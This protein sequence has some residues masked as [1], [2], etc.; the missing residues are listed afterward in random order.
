MTLPALASLAELDARTPGGISAAD[1]VRALAALDD[2]SAMVRSV[3]GKTWT[4]DGVL[5]DDVPHVVVMVTCAVARRVM[6]NP[7]GVEQES[8]DD[9]S[10]S[11]TN[12]SSDIY[13]TAA[14]RAAVRAAAGKSG[15]WTLQTTRIGLDDTQYL[16]VVGQDEPI[17]FLPGG[18]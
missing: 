3:A 12:A 1:E 16:D 14:E 11:L 4:T 18:F 10:Y 8:I 2:A 15:I 9:Y 17:P 13:L 7:D 5:D 6:A